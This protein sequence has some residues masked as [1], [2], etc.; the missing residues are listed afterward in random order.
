MPTASAPKIVCRR[1]VPGSLPIFWPHSRAR[2][3]RADQP[4]GGT[5]RLREVVDPLPALKPA[6]S[7]Q[8]IHCRPP[9]SPS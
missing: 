4:I 3:V 6:M 5:Y 2:A 7:E 9:I 8:R 1:W